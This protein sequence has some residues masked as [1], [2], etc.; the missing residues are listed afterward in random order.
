MPRLGEKADKKQGEK[1]QGQQ[2]IIENDF[3]EW[4]KNTHNFWQR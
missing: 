4:F 2:R 3:I 1:H